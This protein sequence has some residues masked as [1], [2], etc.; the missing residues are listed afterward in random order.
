MSLVAPVVGPSGLRT[1]TGFGY[2][3]DSGDYERWIFEGEESAMRSA[4]DALRRNRPDLSFDCEAFDPPKWRLEVR[5]PDRVEK[6]DDTPETIW[7][8]D[9]ETEQRSGW[10]HAKTQAWFL[11]PSNDTTG[12]TTN[13]DLVEE[14]TSPNPP[15]PPQSYKP[16]LSHADA[17]LFLDL[18]L[19]KADHF[20]TSVHLLRKTQII[21]SKSTVSMSFSFS[22]RI[23]S[24]E[25]LKLAE[26]I[27]ETVAFT[28][29]LIPV[30][31]PVAGY[32]V[33]WFKERARLSQLTNS[34]FQ[35]TQTWR[36][37]RWPDYYYDTAG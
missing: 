6:V 11:L 16:R 37:I 17:I 13:G 23:W 7:E 8:L 31:P 18:L 3:P 1:Q 24:T 9:T 32:I 15:F 12:E 20:Y 27:P 35:I 2:S 14:A 25:Q 33:G 30:I 10:E 28:L 29:D 22:E 5:S 19:G 36:Y 34:K 4:A 21:R 26:P